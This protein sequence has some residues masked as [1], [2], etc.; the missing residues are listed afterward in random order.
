MSMHMYYQ[1]FPTQRFGLGHDG[2]YR[3]RK[4]VYAAWVILPNLSAALAFVNPR[5]GFMA[6]GGFCALP[7]RPYWYRVALFWGPRY[8]IWCYVVFVAVRIYR[9]VGSEFKVFGQEKDRSSSLGVPGNSSVDRMMKLDMDMNRERQ[10]SQRI[11][12]IEIAQDYVECALDDASGVCAIKPKTTPLTDSPK[13]NLANYSRRQSTP[14]WSTNMTAVSEDAILAPPPTLSYPSS[15]RGSQQIGNGVIA[16]DFAPPLRMVDFN[17]RGGSVTSVGSK[18]SSAA[19]SFDSPSGLPCI[20]ERLS[21]PKNVEESRPT[22]SGAL[23][24]RRR[25]IQRQ[26]RLLFIYP[27]IYMLLWVIPLVVNIMNYTDY[28]AQHPVFSIGILQL[29]CVTIMTFADV[30]VFCWRER[31][32]RHIPGSDG[33]FVGSLMFWRYCFGTQWH[34]DRRASR[35]APSYLD[36]EKTLDD[37]EASGSRT[38]LLSTLKRWSLGR[39]S[40]SPRGS[41]ASD[42]KRT[43]SGSTI[44]PTPHKRTFSGGSDRKQMEAELAAER[45]ALERR[46]YEKNR[47]SLQERGS[48]VISQQHVVGTAAL[49]D[50]ERKEWFDQDQDLFADEEEKSGR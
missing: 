48:N 33:T 37:E 21:K 35:V 6:T 18:L 7:I 9:Y 17:G 23:K 8:L 25:L 28:F 15:R 4:W 41:D 40:S 12:S 14:N 10:P 27:C 47:R 42:P 24:L 34:Q 11:S 2:L 31:P 36:D 39:M 50:K 13:V 16:E 32:W 43:K 22:P 3:V 29:V 20:T 49:P 38:G 44:R 19:A 30:T 26:L 1:I 5:S 46:D 45:L